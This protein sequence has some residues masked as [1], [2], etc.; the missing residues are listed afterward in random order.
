MP[1]FTEHLKQWASRCGRGST[2]AQRDQIEQWCREFGD[3]PESAADAAF[4]HL[5]IT[6]MG[7]NDR[8]GSDWPR[9]ADIRQAVT[10]GK[11]RMYATEGNARQHCNSCEGHGTVTGPLRGTQLGDAVKIY[12]S[13]RAVKLK[14]SYACTCSN[15]ERYREV[16]GTWATD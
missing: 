3:I 15:G 8:R 13:E 4:K 2:P 1:T 16:M 14:A 9:Y 10:V 6:I 12:G 5:D 7:A 11:T